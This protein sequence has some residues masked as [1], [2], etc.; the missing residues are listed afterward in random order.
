M[1]LMPKYDANQDTVDEIEL[2]QC[3][4]MLEE[5]RLCDVW[6]QIHRVFGG[7]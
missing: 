4:Y 5:E 3:L 1:A 6:L 7:G 2:N